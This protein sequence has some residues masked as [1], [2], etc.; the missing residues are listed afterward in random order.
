MLH[1]KMVVVV[2]K[3]V[4]VPMLVFVPMISLVFI[5]KH[6]SSVNDLCCFINSHLNSYR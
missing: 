2:N 6:L 1:A 4:P 5:V 3:K